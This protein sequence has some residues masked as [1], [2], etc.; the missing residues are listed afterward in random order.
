MDSHLIPLIKT[1]ITLDIG[2]QILHTGHS[3]WSHA[4]PHTRKRI[5]T[6]WGDPIVSLIGKGVQPP[7]DLQLNIQVIQILISILLSWE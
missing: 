3:P 2:A 5:Q 6:L 1:R 7:K 4:S